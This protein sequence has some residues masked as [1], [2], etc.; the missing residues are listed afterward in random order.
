LHIPFED[1]LVAKT[2]IAHNGINPNQGA[3]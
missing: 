1:E 3:Q 2:C